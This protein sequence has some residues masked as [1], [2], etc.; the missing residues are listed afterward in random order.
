MACTGVDLD[1]SPLN[2]SRKRGREQHELRDE[3]RD[4]ANDGH[5][6][7]DD[8]QRHEDDRD[9]RGRTTTGIGPFWSRITA[10]A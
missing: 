3:P 2:R 9:D 10:R 1:R 4:I 5:A 7:R 6:R 8:D